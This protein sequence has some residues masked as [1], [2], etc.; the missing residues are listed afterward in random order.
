MIQSAGERSSQL[1]ER[2]QEIIPGGVNSPV[3]AFKSVGGTPPFIKR[4]SGA[5][6]WDEDGREYLDYVGSYGPLIFGHA[7]AFVTSA[8]S[9]AAA[10][11]TTYGAPTRLEVELAELVT[12]LIPGME[13]V[14]FVNSGSEA[15]TSAVRLARGATGRSKVIKFAG[16]FH[17]SVDSLLV[18]AGSG[19]ATL[20]IPE[21]AGVPESLASETIVV[22]FNDLPALEQAFARFGSEIAAVIMEPVPANMGVVPPL[23]N[24]LRSVRELTIRHQALLIFDEVI[25]GFRVAA[26]GAQELFQVIPDLTCLGKIVGGGVPS[27]AYGGRRDLMQHLAPVGPVYQAGTLSGNPLAS[28]AGLAVLSEIAGRGPSL[29]QE[30]EEKGRLL[31][32]G[33]VSIFGDAGLAVSVQRVGSLLTPFFRAEPPTNYAEARTCDTSVFSALFHNL[34]QE[35]IYVPPSQYEAWFVSAAHTAAQL[36]KTLEAVRRATKTLAILAGS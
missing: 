21:T 34:L 2:A 33:L 7:P 15:T 10:N 1:F 20:G 36:Q 27:G 31:E 13:M 14:R 35:G 16:C 8:I 18:S 26:G 19:I 29:Y 23:T 25:T 17:G 22:E 6:L 28:S 32:E 3:R 9:T 11:G 5:Q 4:A 24:Y 30:L 12:T